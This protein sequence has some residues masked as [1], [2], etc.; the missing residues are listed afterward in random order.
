VPD[1]VGE[2][3]GDDKPYPPTPLRRQVNV[4]V[5]QLQ[6]H[7]VL[8]EAS[9]RQGRTEARQVLPQIERTSRCWRLKGAVRVGLRP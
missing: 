5:D 7:A 3:F 1:R 2:E 6:P 9:G 4:F 8:G